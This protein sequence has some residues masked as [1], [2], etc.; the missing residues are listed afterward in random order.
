MTSLRASMATFRSCIL[1]LSRLLIFLLSSCCS[2][3][4]S[5][6]WGLVA[7][8]GPWRAPM[9]PELMLS[10]E[11]EPRPAGHL[12]KSCWRE[13]GPQRASDGSLPLPSGLGR[14]LILQAG[15]AEVCW[16]FQRP[17]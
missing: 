6:L 11:P 9:A 13:L 14:M 17:E 16:F 15:E 12:E 3:G 1:F 10:L 8:W 5:S 7:L 2:S 4:L